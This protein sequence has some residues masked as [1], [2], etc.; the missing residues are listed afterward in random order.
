MP[1]S[2]PPSPYQRTPQ[3]FF[4]K[5]I[6]LMP[7]DALQGGKHSWALN[8]RSHEE[9]TI[10]V[11]YGQDLLSS[12]A[13]LAG[14]QSIHSIFRLTDTTPFTAGVPSRRLVGAGAILYGNVPGSTTFT[15]LDT[16]YS[17]DP[18]SFVAAPSYASSRPFAYIADADRQRKINTDQTV[19]SIGLPQ[20]T[21]A[22]TATLAAIQ[23]TFLESIDPNTT[24]I[25]YAEGDT[26]GGAL[27]PNVSRVATVITNL[28]YDVGV[29][30]MCSFAVAS[31]DNIVPGATVN[32]G[33]ALET[34]IIQEVLPPV[35]P[36]TIAAILYDAGNTGLC[37]IQPTGSFSAGQIEVP[38][39]E[40]LAHRYS[41][42]GLHS[43]ESPDTSLVG[44]M[45]RRTRD[46]REQAAYDASATAAMAARD[47]APPP[48]TI[49]RTVDFPV[50]ALILL[51][52]TEVVRILSVAIG[53]D[54]V[55]SF[56]CLT[57]GTFAAGAAISGLGTLRAYSNTTFLV[58]DAVTAQAIEQTFT[59]ATI[60]EFAIGTQAQVTGAG[61]RNW[62][63]VGNRATQPEDIIRF[64]IKVNDL[65]YVRSCRLVL[66]LTNA[67]PQFL[68]EYYFYEWRAA[69]LVTAIQATAETV[70]GLMAEAQR[71]AVEQGQFDAMYRDQYGQQQQDGLSL[72]AG[73]DL[74]ISRPGS[75]VGR[76]RDRTRAA[77]LAKISPV[78]AGGE[79]SRQLALGNDAWMTLECRVG[80]LTRVG[81]DNTLTL[82]TVAR[83]AIYFQIEGTTDPV[84]I[85]WSDA[86][87]TGGYGP[88]VA[89]TLPPYV[90]CYSYRST[91]TGERSNS[92]P[93]MR[94]GVLP[95]R[96]RV[97]LV[98]QTSP[99][100]QCD[101]IDFY[102]FGGALA[103]WTYTGSTV[104][105]PTVSPADAT[106]IDDLADGRI[107]GGESPRVDL[108]QPW[109]TLD[110]PRDGLC[111][112]AGTA[113]ERTSGDLFN[114][115]WAPG[116]P[117]IIN[118]I[119]T[120]LY[121]SPTSTS[122]LEVVDNVGSGTSLAFSIPLP[123]LLSQN[124]PILFGGSIAGA[125]FHF[126]VGDPN[127]PGAVHWTHANNPDCA[128]DAASLIVTSA[129][130][131]LLSGCF[132]G[133]VPYVFSTERPYALE[134]TPGYAGLFRP[135]ELAVDR[136]LWSRWAL[137]VDPNGSG[138]YFL[139]KDGIYRLTGGALTCITRPDLQPLFPLEGTTPEA[140]RNLYPVDM[141]A[142]DVLKL[143]FVGTYLYFDYLDTNGDLRTLVYEP[144]YDR[145]T[146]DVYAIGTTAR[147][148]ETGPDVLAHLMG[149]VDGNLRQFTSLKITDDLTD[150]QWALWTP[151]ANADDPRS[152][153]QFGDAILDMNPGGTTDGIRVTPVMDNGNVALE[154]QIL[155]VGGALRDTYIVEMGAAGG[156][157]TD[158]GYGIWSRNC[159]LWIEGVLQTC[160]I[161]RP[162]LYL[163]EP[164]FVPKG[165]ATGF[166]STDWEDL[167]YKGAKFIQGVVIRANTFGQQKLVD[168]QFDGPNGA[169]QLAMQISLLHDGETTI[170]YPNADTGWQP[171]HA[172]LVRLR[173]A[174][175]G[176]WVLLD[177][178]WV[179]EPAPEDA[180]QWETQDTTFDL[181][182]F[183]TVHD[184]VMAYASD[185]PITLTV[186]HDQTPIAYTL[187]TTNGDYQRVYVRFGPYK[188]KS[189]NFQWY[190]DL[191][192]RLYK[193]DC[194]VRVQ[195]WGQPGGY[196]VVSP[197][198]GPSRADGA[199]I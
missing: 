100:A 134:P 91:I 1:S 144:I 23:T 10:E 188:G 176:E 135:R 21:T 197:F 44:R 143:T 130:E 85:N 3:R 16:G 156:L 7:Q 120:Q 13:P 4:Y 153:K 11:R 154:P 126:A 42:V 133:E 52:G 55:Q 123:T 101:Q 114:T 47:D 94:A 69:D 68:K 174:D 24:W 22:P 64:G 121:R 111:T 57:L 124:L 142:T 74:S 106:Y 81:T 164:S 93:T 27:L 122:R 136:G 182:G 119:A 82:G 140:I 189:V 198:G 51:G 65:G 5:G 145:W 86:Y 109:P 9:G 177:W 43:L 163:W 162:I 59:P 60:A 125:W 192:F 48:V 95:H 141:T 129:S 158:L 19:Y 98:A 161:Q 186:S 38:T 115:A 173:A 139:A 29:T 185:T 20:P 63:L 18:L 76:A 146:P 34:V 12:V 35:S 87:L 72:P 67:D 105:D 167:G 199:G 113:I 175:T 152:Y 118:G 61:G 195:G 166:R 78:S 169:P 54:G 41:S 170:A 104:N 117:I 179:W 196:R 88:D 28:V 128:S 90:Y 116:T 83:A 56:R 26:G 103:R 66:G 147:Y 150:I 183:L 45:R 194:S 37:T 79:I 148:D 70:T 15:S 40:Q 8:I 32:V 160:D 155:G 157:A 14:G 149:G 184:G 89:Q 108:F 137:A 107:D 171:F 190:S 138:A 49:T 46:A 39:A 99:E 172:E 131:P 127:D 30:G 181:P 132:I 110:Q 36:T 97:V 84:I 191:P 31:Y 73:T 58:G 80:D 53:P 168:V 187:P 96:G 112:V 25:G 193:Q 92:S 75:L 2:G 71:N 50:N 102:R 180:T 17:G 178:R 151:W 33:A 6:S 159:G 165:T 62:N 77:R